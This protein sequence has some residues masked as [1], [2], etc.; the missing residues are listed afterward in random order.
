MRTVFTP[1]LA[2]GAFGPTVAQPVRNGDEGHR[3]HFVDLSAAD[4]EAVHDHS[5]LQHSRLRVRSSAPAGSIEDKKDEHAGHALLLIDNHC[6]S[7]PDVLHK[8]ENLTVHL[9]R[10]GEHTHSE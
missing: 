2:P 3:F 5:V 10:A 1:A 4:P 8:S 6:V 9:L 7:R